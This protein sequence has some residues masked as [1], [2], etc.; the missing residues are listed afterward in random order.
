[1]AEPAGA[2]ADA[3]APASA[4][5]FARSGDARAEP[6]R[7]YTEALLLAPHDD[8]RAVVPRVSREL[9]A[10]GLRVRVV[11]DNGPV[12]LGEGS[13]FVVSEQGHVLTCAHVMG[14]AIEAT[15]FF[16]D[17]PHAA[18]L[19]RIDHTADLAL[20]KLRGPLPAGTPVARFRPTTNSYGP[21]EDIFA[22]GFAAKGPPGGGQTLERGTVTTAKG[23]GDAGQ[24][25]TTARFAPGTSGA[26]VLDHE[27]FVI[28]VVTQT[29]NPW[30]LTVP[31]L[32]PPEPPGNIALKGEQV[33]AFLRAG[34]PQAFE[35]LRY[36]RAPGLE[37]AG[38]SVVR[39][40]AGAPVDIEPAHRRLVVRLAYWSEHDIWYRFKFFLLSAFDFDSQDALFT[41][42]QSRDENVS[43]EEVVLA[44]T[45]AQ[46]RSTFTGSGYAR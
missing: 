26:P 19:V 11:E 45:L 40:V 13:G 24:L 8:S 28:G 43:N 22:L 17:Q 1:M 9:A 14:D 31:G 37:G 29:V 18:D 38:R 30:R 12:D 39:I 25:P 41:V 4:A 10:L 32:D 23:G 6:F 27:G 44:N 36:D 3:G 2:A 34:S 5:A 7:H 33:F 35:S 16:N 42:G 20:L 21:G 46:F 15:V